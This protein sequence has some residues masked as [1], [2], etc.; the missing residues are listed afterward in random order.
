MI[1]ISQIKLP[2]NH[3]D[4]DLEKKVCKLLHIDKSALVSI[5]VSKKSLDARKKPELMFVYTVDVVLKNENKINKK[6]LSGNIAKYNPVKYEFD[7]FGSEKLSHRPVIIGMGPAGLFAA[8]LLV[9]NGY[10]PIILERGKS[11]EERKEDVDKYWE[12]GVL[13]ITSNVQFGEGGAGTFSDGKLNTVVKDKGGKNSFVLE[14]FCK[15]G[16]DKE[17][18]YSNKPHIGTDV[19][20]DVVKNMRNEIIQL[21]GE[22]R[23][24]SQVTDFVVENN[25]LKALV[26]NNDY[27]IDCDVA[28]LAIG[29]SARDTFEKLNSIGIKMESKNFAVGVRIQHPQEW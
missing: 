18:M 4:S 15:F 27:K 13:D 24:Q 9:K 28:V 6:I 12:T 20:I 10:K 23:F 25:S 5:D 29:H 26:I 2:I 1:R 21:G 7:A 17:I 22:V 14:T 11:V 19:L 16:A 3:S 8:Y